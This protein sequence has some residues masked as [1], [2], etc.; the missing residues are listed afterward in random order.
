MV[1]LP[2]EQGLYD[3][4]NEHDACGIGF[5]VNIEGKQS[6]DI[7]EKGLQI[8]INLA[9][10]GACGC[11][12]ET[13]DGAGILIQIP[14]KFFVRECAQLGFTLPPVG[15][16]GVGMVFLPVEPSHRLIAE[17]ILE[18][19]TR[20]EGLVVLGW[21]DTPV[22][23][24]A[25]GRIARAS[26]PYIEQIFIAAAPGMSQDQLERKL[27]IVRKRAESEI[28]ASDLPDKNFFYIPSLSS[29]TI[30]YKGLLLANQIS[31]FYQEL[32][33]PD[34]VSALCLVHQR[35]STNTFP[36]WQLAHPYRYLC[37]N[38]EINTVRG[39][40]N[41]M[42][43]REKVLSS[44]VFGDDF[45]KLLPIIAPGGSDSAS[46]DNA[47]EL[48][49][50]SGRSLPHVM[51]ML[52]PEA[53]DADST[54]RPEKKAF[55]EYH[56]SLM[57]PW[58]GP[59][60]IAFT[61]G[62]SIGATLDR[63]GLR[64]ARYLVTH[65]GLVILGSETGVLPV[66]PEEVKFK[67]RLQPGKMLLVDTAEGRIVPDE[68]I[69]ERL[70][71]RQP[72]GEWLKQN[73][74]TLDSLPE[75]PRVYDSDLDSIVMRQRAFGYTDEDLRV[76]MLPMAEK[77]EEP[78]GSMGTDTP[79]ACLSDK[80][81]PLFHY[82][83]Q[84]FAQVTNPAID[85]IREELVMSLTSY[86]GTERNILEET[87]QHCHTLK[88]PHPLLT[89]RDL[90]KLR[91]VSAGDL[92]A[93]T[94]PM[95]FRVAGGEKELERALDGLCRRASLAVRSG[96]S[97]LILTDRGMDDEYAP[98]PSLLALSAVHNYLVREGTRTQVAL[99]IESG[100]PREVMHFCLLIGYG[101]SAV[102]PYLAIETLEDEAAQGAS[103]S[104]PDI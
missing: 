74:I 23:A 18:R 39:N 33:D 40:I 17:G 32:T 19:I 60:A 63:N 91:R 27:Y 90:E 92:L 97:L 6:H 76:L 53:W 72:Y 42:H 35:F 88:L 14:D 87:P 84:L 54:M 73:Q 81:Q 16:Y 21:R 51:A 66:K 2:V 1:G 4:R 12:P 69:K 98:I 31:E 28:A 102:N 25:I 47:V 46:L 83:K 26:Q 9:H 55:Y 96:Y 86:I 8:L 5:V 77:G 24:D 43:A 48:L 99:I 61:D 7:I 89:N 80:P 52:I 30:I 103:A 82:F 68:E 64:P 104:R 20:E 58:D 29:R 37:H 78:I 49:T 57:E 13:G 67:G 95:L 45:K 75:P 94:L 100:E 79:L 10:R 85:P 38:G 56:A 50:L 36:S 71:S 93:N 70:W 44:H 11:D 59:A 62:R 101:A 15:E 41:W 3:P 65:D 22:E 34:A